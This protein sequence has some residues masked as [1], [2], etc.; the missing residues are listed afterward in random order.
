MILMAAG[1]PLAQ[2]DGSRLMRLQGRISSRWA[3]FRPDA[4]GGTA[5]RRLRRDGSARVYG[6]SMDALR[7]ICALGEGIALVPA[8]YGK[9][10]VRPDEGVVVRPLARIRL[11]RT[12]VVAWR[13]SQ[14]EPT[15]ARIVAGALVRRCGR[16]WRMRAAE[17]FAITR[18][19]G[20]LFRC[21]P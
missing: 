11:E 8:L 13:Q 10:E 18:R 19:G 9:S 20:G 17:P 16:R 6:Y 3:R 1:H 15:V 7:L 21:G 2:F 12:L 4:D 5:G 14:G